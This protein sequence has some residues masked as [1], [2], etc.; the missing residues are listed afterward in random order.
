MRR[1]YLPLVLCLAALLVVAASPAAANSKPT[2]GTRISFF[3][4]P[5][6]FAANTPF[7]IEHGFGCDTTI[8]DKVS[9]CMNAST[10][11]DLHLDGVL[12]RSTVDVDNSPTFY[13]KRNLTN[14]PAGLPAGSHTFVGDFVFNGTTLLTLT[15]T[16]TFS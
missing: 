11:F 14:Y 4:P 15:I 9:D 1:R 16:V 2:T 8:G 13:L 7:Y 5:G 10:H 3:A 6:T 12:Q